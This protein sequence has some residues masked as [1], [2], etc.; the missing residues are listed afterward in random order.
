MCKELGRLFQGFTCKLEA[1]HMVQGTNTCIF[2]SRKDIPQ[3]KKATYIRI[4]SEMRPQK[5]DPYRVRCTVG[6]NQ[7][8]FP[9]DKSTKVAELV[10]IKILFNNIVST[11][12]AKAGCID[13]KDFYLNN[14]LPNYEY[15]FFLASLIPQDFLDQYRDK[16]I[17]D[18]NG[19]VY[20]RVEKGMYGLPQ[21]G[22]VASDALLPRLKQAGY[23]ETGR[24]PGL[25]K[26]KTNSIIFALV[27]DD[28]L[29]QYSDTAHFAHLSVTLQKN[30]TITTDM[31]AS[32]FCGISLKWDYVA[33]HV[34]L[35]MPGYV[36]AALQRFTHPAPTRPQ[37]SP[38]AWIAPNYGARVQYA[39]SEEDSIPLDKAGI[40]RLQEV[41]GTFLYSARAVD[42]TMLVA[43]GTLAAAQTKG[44][45]HTMKALAQLLDYAATHPDAAIRFHKSDMILYAHSDASYLSEAQA[46][47][48]VGSYFYLGNV[49]EAQDNP[50]PN[51]PIHVESRILKNIMASA[52]EAEIAAL[53]HNGQARG[54]P[55][56]PNPCRNRQ[57]PNRADPNH[58]R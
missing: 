41:I 12:G 47:S 26:H 57:A 8:D 54:R 48:R 36:E 23:V 3:G 37:H 52:S 31:E 24:I 11:D 40:K 25:F 9:G 21:A 18:D 4:V 10:T 46:R 22:K 32:K 1:I 34:T 44:T 49:N 17:I 15:V 39:P 35:S 20:A 6:G 50:R 33:R 45:E 53:F 19:H 43:L 42:N 2:I 28:F 29:V 56:P 55:Y 13:I 5:A 30:Y 51:G 27:V 14:V 38:H 16:I 58:N 7:I